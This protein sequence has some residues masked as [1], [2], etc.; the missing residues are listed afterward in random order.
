MTLGRPQSAR[1]APPKITSKP[2]HCAFIFPS[3]HASGEQCASVAVTVSFQR[4]VVARGG[5]SVGSGYIGKAVG[6]YN[7]RPV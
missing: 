1:G 3:A 6:A 4:L 7:D 2:V 5:A